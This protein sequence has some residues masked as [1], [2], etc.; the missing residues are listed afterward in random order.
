MINF[1]KKLAVI[2]YFEMPD[3]WHTVPDID[4]ETE[5]AVPGRDVP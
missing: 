2:T 5:C 1:E 4:Y 3:I